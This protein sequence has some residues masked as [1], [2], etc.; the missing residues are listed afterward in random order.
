LTGD[1]R[2]VF[3][4][5][6]SKCPPFACTHARRRLRHSSIALSMMLWS[7]LR[8]TCCTHCFSSSSVVRPWLVHSLLDDAP[9]PVI[10]RI[11]VRAARWPKIRWNERRHCSRSRSVA[12]RCARAF[13][14]CNVVIVA[15][16]C[17]LEQKLPLTAYRKSHIRNRL[18]PK[19]ITLTF[20]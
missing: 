5:I 6:C 10:N 1:R 13:S 8:H 9:D 20:I 3:Y 17:V 18:V 11:K 15:K 14:V 16:R 19:W 12:C 4:S 7:T 2:I